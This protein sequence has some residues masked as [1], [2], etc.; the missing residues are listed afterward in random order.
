MLKVMVFKEGIQSVFFIVCAF[1]S[2]LFY[3]CNGV[4][5]T[6]DDNSPITKVMEI[7]STQV[8]GRYM[9]DSISFPVFYD[10]K[11]NNTDVILTVGK[12]HVFTG[13]NIPDFMYDGF[14][15]SK[16]LTS[17]NIK[18]E[19]ELKKSSQD[20]SLLIELYCKNC[21]NYNLEHYNL[22]GELI[23]LN[24]SLY[25]R[26]YVGDPDSDDILMFRNIQ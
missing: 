9:V 19:W 20:E 21:K 23:K 2:F 6:I 10:R 1:I 8:I 3:S 13:V 14:G 17:M 18:G 12:N 15:K 4:I 5:D 11:V 25:L 16:A 22:N 24:N 26:F 7:D